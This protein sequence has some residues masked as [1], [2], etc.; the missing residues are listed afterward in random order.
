MDKNNVETELLIINL[1]LLTALKNGCITIKQM[2]EVYQNMQTMG[3]IEKFNVR[4][5]VKKLLMSSMR[6]D[7]KKVIMNNIEIIN[8]DFEDD[9]N[10]NLELNIELLNKIEEE[11]E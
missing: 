8:H 4:E 7:I 2:R 3:K 1:G 10:D 5:E 9:V 11:L 6:L